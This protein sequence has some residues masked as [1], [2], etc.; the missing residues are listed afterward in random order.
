MNGTYQASESVDVLQVRLDTLSQSVK[1]E[2][3]SSVVQSIAIELGTQADIGE[4]VLK[5]H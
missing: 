1:I 3:I 4:G 2:L 5:V